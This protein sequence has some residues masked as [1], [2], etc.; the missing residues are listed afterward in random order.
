MQ[1]SVPVIG[2]SHIPR[3]KV[4]VFGT[5]GDIAEVA[6]QSLLRA[7]YEVEAAFNHTDL[8]HE[9]IKGDVAVIAGEKI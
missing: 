7:G 1:Q 2:E 6:Q 9:G 3:A 8:K 5:M 4:L